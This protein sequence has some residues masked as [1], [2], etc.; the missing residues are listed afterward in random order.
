MGGGK[1]GGSG[2]KTYDY[3]GTLCVPIRAG[4]TDNLY[5]ILID[6]KA[7]WEGS[8]NRSVGNPYTVPLSDPKWLLSGGYLKIYWG[9]DNQTTPDAALVVFCVAM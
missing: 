4:R 1:S 7:I 8:I 5:A 6:G 3:Y 9:L 2:S